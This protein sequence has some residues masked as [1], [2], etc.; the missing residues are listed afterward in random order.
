[1]LLWFCIN[2]DQVLVL[3][4]SCLASPCLLW[5]RGSHYCFQT[6]NVTKYFYFFLLLIKY[7][8]RFHLKYFLLVLMAIEIEASTLPLQVS[9]VQVQ[10]NLQDEYLSESESP[11]WW[12]SSGRSRGIHGD[13]SD[14]RICHRSQVCDGA[15]ISSSSSSSV[16]S[17][18]SALV[19]TLDRGGLE[20]CFVCLWLRN[21]KLIVVPRCS[22]PNF[23]DQ[24][25]LT[26]LN[27]AIAELNPFTH[28]SKQL[29]K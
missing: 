26:E 14:E 4:E 6:G 27:V 10:G 12:H 21:P 1:M 17:L 13:S 19:L 15:D 23:R 29:I 2:F 8:W 3:R 5:R 24:Q 28:G 16:S 11:P 20:I 9:S 25:T 22:S 18:W 7:F